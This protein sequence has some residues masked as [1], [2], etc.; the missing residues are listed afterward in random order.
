MTDGKKSKKQGVIRLR[1][2]GKVAVRGRIPAGVMTASQMAAVARIAEEFG[3]GEVAM[4]ARLNVG[5]RLQGH[6][7]QARVLRH[8]GACPGHRGAVRGMRSPEETEDLDR[9]VPEQLRKGPAQ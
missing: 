4:T 8:A 3:N 7:L 1:E 6:G 2:K 9:G 5:R